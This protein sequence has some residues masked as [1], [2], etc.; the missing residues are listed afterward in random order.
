MTRT[1]ERIC[2]VS[3]LATCTYR[4][5]VGQSG[6][7]PVQLAGDVLVDLL[8]PEALEPPRGPRA[9]VSEAVPAIDDD[10]AGAI[11]AGGRRLGELAERD[12][13]CARQVLLA[14]LVDR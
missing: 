7:Q 10:R 12:I 1:R 8:E 4:H 9:H 5:M 14:V 11:Q 13:A 6:R 2:L 3:P